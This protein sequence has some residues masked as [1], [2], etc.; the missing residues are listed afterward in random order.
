M[1]RLCLRLTVKKAL[2]ILFWSKPDYIPYAKC[3]LVKHKN[4]A[5][6]TDKPSLLSFST[7]LLL[8]E[9]AV[10]GQR[11]QR[12]LSLLNHIKHT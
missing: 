1:H 4:Q 8:S 10:L 12:N 2:K 9:A 11:A 5:S 7:T 6:L 3:R